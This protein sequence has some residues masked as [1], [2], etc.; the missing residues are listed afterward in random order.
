MQVEA[1]TVEAITERP[2]GWAYG[3]GSGEI[4]RPSHS[5]AER[6]IS[7]QAILMWLFGGSPH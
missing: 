6:I 1:E 3:F 5:V 2:D 4:H 7:F